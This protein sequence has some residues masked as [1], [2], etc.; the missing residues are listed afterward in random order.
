MIKWN[1][2]EK[3]ARDRIRYYYSTGTE[4]IIFLF[5]S[6]FFIGR[7]EFAPLPQQN[8]ESLWTVE[9]KLMSLRPMNYLAKRIGGNKF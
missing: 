5:T 9:E 1:T 3:V 4:F 7:K 6:D 8:L 2:I